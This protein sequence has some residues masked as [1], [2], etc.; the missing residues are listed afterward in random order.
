MA[1]AEK[2]CLGLKLENERP[3]KTMILSLNV[4][5]TVGYWDTVP[6]SSELQLLRLSKLWK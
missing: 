4:W 5:D 1:G 3:K 2:G 6:H